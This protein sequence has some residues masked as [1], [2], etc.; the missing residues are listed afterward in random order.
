[1][2]A[3][4][5]CGV[6]VTTLAR[7]FPLSYVLGALAARNEVLP[8]A[9][10]SRGQLVDGTFST[11]SVQPLPGG[12]VVFY[13]A[14]CEKTAQSPVDIQGYER[15]QLNGLNW[16]R[17]ASG[18]GPVTPAPSGV[19]VVYAID[20]PDP[21]PYTDQ[22]TYTA[23]TG[24]VLTTGIASVVVRF[25]DGQLVRDEAAGT[26]FVILVA[27]PMKPCEL[28]LRDRWGQVVYSEDLSHRPAPVNAG[29]C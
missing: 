5:L 16:E 11:A 4:L 26:R 9:C 2:V 6:Y 3:A 7:P 12:F 20:G 10:R 17:T 22:P 15:F 1:M 18:S 21:G 24:Q 14:T 13:T 23:V 19:P 28:Q 25:A 29:T 8:R 27:Q